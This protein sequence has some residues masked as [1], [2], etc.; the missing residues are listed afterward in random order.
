MTKEE[1]LAAV[2]SAAEQNQASR[3]EI[4]SAYD[5]GR[6]IRPGAVS[7]KKLG[8]AEIL[9]YL[10][11]AIIFLGIVILL[12]QNWNALGI[13]A[14]LLATLGSAIA[15]YV[16]GIYLGQKPETGSM[17]AAFDLVAA[18]VFPIGLY[19]ALDA[20]GVVLGLG[21]QSIVSAV[22]FVLY[23]AS[24]YALRRNLPAFFSIVFGT[25]FFF[26]VTSFIASGAP[27]DASFLELRFL[28][29]GLSWMLLGYYFSGRP[30][31]PLT[32]ALYGFGIFAFL[33]AALAL[34]GFRPNQNPFWELVFP[35]LVFGAIF[36]S[37][38]LKSKPFL[39]FGTLF[40]MA[41]II[42]LTAEYFSGSLGWPVALVIAGL[43]LIA[44]GY[45]SLSLRKKYMLSG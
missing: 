4:N 39:A 19:V 2:K 40:L 43:L 44:V 11:G 41:Y 13:P 24:Y 16:L 5:A 9:Y 38:Y 25:W 10:G 7:V 15:A 32:G 36:L 35:L 26:A 22:L 14:R 28:A 23:L 34:G 21:A 42:K 27:V 8:L 1:L 18:L 31:R 12:W 29:A 30:L 37:V 17:G 6:G 45:M 33:A 3:E 20:A